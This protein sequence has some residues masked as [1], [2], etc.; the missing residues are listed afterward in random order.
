L[1]PTPR[2]ACQGFCRVP[3]LGARIRRLSPSPDESTADQG[4]RQVAELVTRAYFGQAGVT[5]ASRA[6]RQRM[7]ATTEMLKTSPG[8]DL[9]DERSLSDCIEACFECAQSC[10]ACA[11]ACL[12]EENVAELRACIR[13]NLAC[14]DLCEITGRLLSRRL[15]PGDDLVRRQID[16]TSIACAQCAEECG[17]HAKMHA[18]C[19]ICMEACRRCEATCRALTAALES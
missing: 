12:D 8:R 15:T 1:N 6:R 11:D 17:R 3:R 10:V 19:K 18:H 9:T 7:F 4:R 5:K 2:A 14:A 13:L 16:L